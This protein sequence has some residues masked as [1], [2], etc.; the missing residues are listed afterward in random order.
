[1]TGKIKRLVSDRVFGFIRAENETEYFFH[2]DDVKNA[3]WDSLREGQNVEFE[4]AESTKGPR[5]SD[6]FLI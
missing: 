5:A 3:S 4:E 2:K 6:V 1:M